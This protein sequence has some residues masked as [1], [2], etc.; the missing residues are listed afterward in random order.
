MDHLRQGKRRADSDLKLCPKSAQASEGL[1]HLLPAAERH[2]VGKTPLTTQFSLLQPS[3][4]SK[5]LKHWHKTSTL[6]SRKTYLLPEGHI[7]YKE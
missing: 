6:H 7:L 4:V 5:K 1:T 3:S 2:P